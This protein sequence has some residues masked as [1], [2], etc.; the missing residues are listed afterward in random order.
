MAQPQLTNTLLDDFLQELPADFQE[1][2]YELQAFARARK[3]R[4]PLQPGRGR[5]APPCIFISVVISYHD[6]RQK[7]LVRPLKVRP[8][9]VD[10]AF[11]LA[12]DAN[13]DTER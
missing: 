12:S 10:Q 2:A 6:L 4:S 11:C 8:S 7:E 1:R 5:D 13:L 3:I 9:R